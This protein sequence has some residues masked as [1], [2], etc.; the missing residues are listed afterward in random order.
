[1]APKRKSE[2]SAAT[3]PRRSSRHAD[4]TSTTEAVEEPRPAQA[5]PKRQKAEAAD[6]A[7]VGQSGEA[8]RQRASEK[9]SGKGGGG[10]LSVGDVLPDI[11]LKDDSSADVTLSEVAKTHGIVLF[12]YPAAS[13]PGCTSQGCSY[14][15]HYA[16]IT[17]KG[18]RVFGI[19][20]DTVSAQDK[21]KTKQG[22]QCEWDTSPWRERCTDGRQ[23]PC[24]PTRRRSFSPS[25]AARARQ[26]RRR[27]GVTGCSRRAG[28]CVPWRST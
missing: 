24:S 23:I 12:S 25:S 11:C 26:R 1:M 5:E 18:Y 21:F 22:F 20:T 3:E 4:K 10:R 14:R 28:S 8:D 15:D 16:E 27:C 9:K 2:G 7:A 17:E 6:E 19:S 13:T